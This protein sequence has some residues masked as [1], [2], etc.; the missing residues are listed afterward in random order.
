VSPESGDSSTK[1]KQGGP[2]ST[3]EKGKQHPYHYAL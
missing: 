3:V 1:V 2:A